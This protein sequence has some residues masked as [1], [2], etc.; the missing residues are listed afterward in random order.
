M[1]RSR[2]F[3]LL[4]TA[5][6]PTLALV[7]HGTGAQQRDVVSSQVAVSGSEAS[8]R[9][10]FADG[11]RLALRFA[12]G[13]ATLDGEVLGRYEP[14]GAP[15]RAWRNL[16]ADVL[17]LSD[18]PLARELERWSP[19]PGLEGDDLELL[20]RVDAALEGALTSVAQSPGS[21][22]PQR[23]DAVPASPEARPTAA[24]DAPSAPAPPSPPDFAR[25]RDEIRE[26]VRD[27]VRD[28]IRRELE[29]TGRSRSSGYS[30][31]RAL[32]AAGDVLGAVFTYLVSGVLALLLMRFAGPRLDSV[33][34]EI[35]YRP[36]RAAAVGFAGGFL[37]LP[38]FV[39]GIVALAVSLIGIPLLLVWVPLFPLL[40]GLAAFAGY[41]GV[42][43]HV[44]RWVV[45]HEWPWLDRVDGTRD[46][47]VRLIGL[48]ALMLPFAAGG[49]IGALP[50]IGW[51]GGLLEVLGSIAGLAAVMVGFGA[52]IITRGGRYATTWPGHPDD[53]LETAA[54]WSPVDD[55]DGS[56][57]AR[58]ADDGPHGHETG[59][60]PGE[61]R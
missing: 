51:A 2:H 7:P 8:L 33:T 10:E 34:R 3:I 19:G 61:E 47:H 5:L 42:S 18:G 53:E 58:E 31:P 15:D 39:I 50:L 24:P 13:V 25:L 11:G 38:V 30:A 60:M 45:E 35:G 54:E 44:G 6:V 9:L 57:T 14:G 20:D 41:V 28:E 4:L 12:D 55:M 59:D 26:E 52:V 40:A 22:D 56:H 37:L 27:E 36:G 49:A 32:R 17:S 16:L 29:M 23:P 21:A 43:H 48:A 46:T 1:H